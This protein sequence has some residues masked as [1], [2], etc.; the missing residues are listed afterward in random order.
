VSFIFAY[1]LSKANTLKAEK[2]EIAT[3]D[4]NMLNTNGLYWMLVET[5]IA[6]IAVNLPLLYGTSHHEDVE[7]VIRSVQ[8]FTSIHSLGSHS[9]PQ[10]HEVS[11]GNP[12]VT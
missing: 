1:L 2:T 10:N 4:P 5:G 9:H 8:S 3:F 12:S 6:L 7:S 11:S